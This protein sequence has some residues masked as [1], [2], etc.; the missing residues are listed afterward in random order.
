M[1]HHRECFPGARL[2]ISEASRIGA[3]KSAAYQWL[4]TQ[5]VDLKRT[6]FVKLL[7]SYLLIGAIGIENIVKCEVV[8][9]NKLR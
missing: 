3:F 5:V 9:L 8:R 7:G 6:F 1:S 2:P 4:D